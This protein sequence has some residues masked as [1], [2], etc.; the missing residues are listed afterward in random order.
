MWASAI[1]SVG[2]GLRVA[3][4]CGGC[5]VGPG[6][7]GLSF[8]WTALEEYLSRKVLFGNN[9]LIVFSTVCNFVN[10]KNN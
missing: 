8:R 3:A 10:F 9:G 7:W 2:C 1:F 5:G 6:F 4:G